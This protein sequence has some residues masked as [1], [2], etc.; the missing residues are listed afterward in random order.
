MSQV[1]KRLHP[2]YQH[3]HRHTLN[4]KTNNTPNQSH[5]IRNIRNHPTKVRQTRMQRTLS[6]IRQQ[7]NQNRQHT[8]T[9]V[10]LNHPISHLSTQ[11]GPSNNK[12]TYLK[13]LKTTRI[14]RRRRQK[15]RRTHL[16]AQKSHN[17]TNPPPQQYQHTSHQPTTNKL[18][19]KRQREPTHKHQPYHSVS[20]HITI[21]HR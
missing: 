9:R 13:S 11:T 6:Q 7:P 15:N 10:L 16:K 8:S 14:L 5:P 18:A 17:S 19:T 2:P 20:T 21:H 1:Q 4:P 12:V 3:K